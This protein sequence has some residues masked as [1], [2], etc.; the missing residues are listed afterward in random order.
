MSKLQGWS[1]WLYVT[2]SVW[3]A[4]IF[5][6][7]SVAGC[8]EQQ[9]AQAD[10]AVADVNDIAAGVKAFLESPAGAAIPLD[11]RLYGSLGVLATSVIANGWQ[12]FRNGTM[13]KTTKA[14]VK[15]IEH[16]ERQ[17]N[18]KPKETAVVKQAIAAEM[19][20]AGIFDRGNQL[21]DRLKM[22]R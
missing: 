18:P 20:T 16:V 15:G 6:I 21:V 1:L 22:A 11:W 7:A 17:S 3:L 4:L 8:N 2:V 14:I 12:Q 13:K 19:R 10:R 9:M 5:G